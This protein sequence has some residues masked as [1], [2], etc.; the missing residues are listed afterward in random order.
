VVNEFVDNGS[1]KF[2]GKAYRRHEAR[3]T[4]HVDIENIRELVS[5]ALLGWLTGGLW[6][7]ILAKIL[8]ISLI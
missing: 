1:F 7:D 2:L 8:P 5:L 3:R 6:F 4:S